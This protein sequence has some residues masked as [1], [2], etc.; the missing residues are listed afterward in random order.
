MKVFWI[1]FHY[2]WNDPSQ[3]EKNCSLYIGDAYKLA[4]MVIQ[5][6][7]IV[8]TPFT[9]VVVSVVLYRGALVSFCHSII[10]SLISI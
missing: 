6:E 10:S 3:K 2:A 5:K 4:L 8:I 7:S 9:C 1:S